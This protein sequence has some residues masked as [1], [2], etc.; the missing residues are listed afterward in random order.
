MSQLGEL[1]GGV[2]E[3]CLRDWERSVLIRFALV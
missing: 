3:D 1:L 2:S